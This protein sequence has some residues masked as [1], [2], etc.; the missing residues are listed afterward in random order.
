MTEKFIYAVINRAIDDG[1]EL[2]IC[3][4]YGEVGYEKDNEDGC[5]YFA[6]WNKYGRI[7]NWLEEKG[8][9]IHWS[10]EWII[11]YENDR[12]FRNQPDSYSWRSSYVL[13]DVDQFLTKEDI[14]KSNEVLEDY[15]DYYLLNEYDRAD[16]FDIDFS[17]LGFEKEDVEYKNDWYGNNATPE[18]IYNNLNDLGYDVIFQIDYVHQFGLEF[19]V[20]KRKI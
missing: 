1:M 10:D 8:N 20:W 7:A 15:V 3:G 18:V 16:N 17:V 12:C 14:E 4:E 6:N 11:D 13:T 19:S 2:T 9:E 5:I